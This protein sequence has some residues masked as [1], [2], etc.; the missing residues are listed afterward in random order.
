MEKMAA[1]GLLARLLLGGLGS[2]FLGQAACS[3]TAGC[4]GRLE[5]HRERHGSIYSPAW[6][7]NYPP[8]QNCSWY[9][10]GDSGDLITVSFQS[11]EL[12]DS[13]HCALDWLVLGPTPKREE[14]R[15][16]GSRS[17]PPFI[18]S[19][20]HVWIYF[21]SD[22]SSAGH[23]RGFHLS[24]IRGKLG[25][26]SCQVD[27]FLC[28]NGKCIP[29]AWRCNHMDECGDHSDESVC[30]PETVA[31]PCPAGTLRCAFGQVSRCLPSAALCNGAEDC[32]DGRDE[33]GCPDT[34]C[35]ERLG[36]FFGSFASPDYFRRLGPGLDCTW[37]VDTQ[38][39]RGLLLQLDLRLGHGDSVRVYD[40]T[41]AERGKLIRALSF[42]NNRGTVSLETTRG[43]LTIAYHTPATSSG[44]GFNAT[45]Q[46]KGYCLPW[47][48]P[49]GGEG[50]CYTTAQ[51]CDGWWHCPQGR[52]EEG[53]A[54]CQAG[55]YPCGG[56]SGACYPPPHRC[57][58]QK[59]CPDGS[60]EKNCFSCQPGNFHCGT[61][62][63]IFEQ[64]RCDGQEDCQDGSDE[65][66]CLV[67]VP[68]KVITAALIGSLV[69]GLLLII[70]LGCGFKLYSLRSR[71]YRAFE[72]PMTRLE[73]EFV[74]REAPPSYGQLIAQ[75]LIPP[76]D[77]FPAYNPAQNSVLENLR[78]A[79]RR[80]IRRHSSRR[81]SSRRRL[82]RMW[83]RLFPRPRG[84]G[85]IPLLTPAM[86]SA[87]APAQPQ[88][89]RSCWQLGDEDLAVPRVDPDS[90]TDTE[91]DRQGAVGLPALPVG[92]ARNLLPKVTSI[93]AVEPGSP[94]HSPSPGSLGSHNDLVA[95][96][97][98]AN[99]LMTSAPG[100]A[101]TLSS[102]DETGGPHHTDTRQIRPA[103]KEL[104][105]VMVPSSPEPD[106]HP[107]A[108]QGESLSPVCAAG[109]DCPLRPPRHSVS[110]HKHLT[111]SAGGSSTLP[112][113]DR[114]LLDC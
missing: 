60:D 101:L 52:D 100:T 78:T 37:V 96:G 35:G 112:Q 33:Q 16:C 20:D 18:S 65:R 44:H 23:S 39:G 104:R 105:G 4:Q 6:P 45:Y 63:C 8:S 21:R 49:C 9:I 86:P 106:S 22:C 76:V 28:G 113:G 11:F 25:Q 102:C 56:T 81:H 114:A 12:E 40:S 80:Q 83:S 48:R 66:N 68:R 93:S 1:T 50:G 47:E 74:Q 110:R 51:R 91:T 24:Y 75:G 88:G 27:E 95:M 82:G 19:R 15:L 58:N 7:A 72:T 94:G 92:E 108:S 90:D 3:V 31:E 42:R 13:P 55:E 59:N 29:S 62:L 5:P 53:C 30:V 111:S 34:D 41:A 43:Q 97:S 67:T 109:T 103:G 26:K 57:N 99:H 77:D 79:M 2:L 54:G 107:H 10:Q 73:A 17:P 64:W 70:A 61:Q 36:K 84:W 69:C 85:L 38:D 87:S 32:S 89:P 71:Q 98:D 14:R 46:V